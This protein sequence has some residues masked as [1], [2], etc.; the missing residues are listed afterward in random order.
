LVLE[1]NPH[2]WGRDENNAQLPYLD[3]VRVTFEEDKNKEFDEL[4]KGHLSALLELPSGHLLE[5]KDSLESTTGKQRFVMR[6]MPAFTSQFY[7]FDPNH[8]PFNDPR[9]RKAFSLAIDRDLL[10]DSVLG[11]MASAAKHGLV[12]PGLKGYPYADVPGVPF[13]PDSARRLLAEAGYPNGAGFPSIQLQVNADGF[14]YVNVAEA[15]QNMVQRELNVPISVTVVRADRHYARVDRGQVRMWREGWTADHP[16]PENFL[17]LLYGKNVVSDTSQPSLLNKSRYNNA[18]FNAAFSAALNSADTSERM[19][20]LA[21]AEGVAMKDMPIAPLYHEQAI[22]LLQPR[23]RGLHLN[24]I[25]YL[26]L[27]G[28]WLEKDKAP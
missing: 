13:A 25:E 11:G 12:A 19:K 10:V 28:V 6:S 8:V 22:Y 15:V 16:D 5:L 21:R 18:E 4:L 2:Y 26:D 14:A 24:P 9:V 3:G 27:S 1:R 17:S 20:Q 7:G 23:I